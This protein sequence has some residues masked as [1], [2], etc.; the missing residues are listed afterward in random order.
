ML[1]RLLDG[2][3]L[4]ES[5]NGLIEVLAWCFFRVMEEKHK[6]PQPG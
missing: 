1:G 3:D 2:K 6:R 4:E 5:V